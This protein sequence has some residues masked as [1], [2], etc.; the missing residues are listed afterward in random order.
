MKQSQ[1]YPS[2]C[3]KPMFFP[4]INIHILKRRKLSLVYMLQHAAKYQ[5]NLSSHL[6]STKSMLTPK[7]WK[8]A[9][10]SLN[11]IFFSKSEMMS[12]IPR[13]QST[14]LWNI[15]WI[16]SSI[17][18]FWVQMHKSALTP[19]VWKTA[20]KSP[21]FSFFKIWLDEYHALNVGHHAVKYQMNPCSHHWNPNLNTQILSTKQTKNSK[22]NGHK[23]VKFQLFQNPKRRA[24]S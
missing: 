3:T 15:R 18:K 24:S 17:S 8:N 20:I 22:K 1:S 12:I 16:H 7:V 5:M 6:R 10:E 19:K 11:F 9:I 14:I 23:I 2:I 4:G 21:N 13:M